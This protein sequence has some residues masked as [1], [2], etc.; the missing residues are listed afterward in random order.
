MSF[1]NKVI[2]DINM[3]EERGYTKEERPAFVFLFGLSAYLQ[4]N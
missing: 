2:Q 4:L 1:Y 3:V